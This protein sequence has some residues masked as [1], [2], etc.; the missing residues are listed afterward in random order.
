MM[1]S[2]SNHMELETNIRVDE[3]HRENLVKL[4]QMSEAEILR[5]KSILES[6]L[7]PDLIKF[8]KNRK[9]NFQQS[10]TNVIES[11]AMECQDIPD[12]PEP[13]KDILETGKSKGW[14]H[15][16]SLEPEKLKWM[17]DLP[18]EEKPE[19]SPSEPYTARFDFN[20]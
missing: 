7:K 6:T 15:M 17:K 13:S 10:E 9:K 18:I 5:E 16:D 19:S 20:G 1:N 4:N 14:I 11:T 8:L 12:L 2:C 3:I